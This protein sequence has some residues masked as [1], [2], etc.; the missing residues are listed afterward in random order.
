MSI[1]QIKADVALIVFLF[2]FLVSVCGTEFGIA[3]TSAIVE[4]ASK[5]SYLDKIEGKFRK[6]YFPPPDLGYC[7]ATVSFKLARDGKISDIQLIH[8][9]KDLK[10]PNLD[11]LA[12]RAVVAGVKNLEPLLQV[13]KEINCP[14]TIIMIIDGRMRGPMQ[15]SATFSSEDVSNGKLKMGHHKTHSRT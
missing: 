2:V 8:R 3:Q 7:I 11:D 4:K 6:V 5:Q 10:H 15:I 13:P 14:V 1:K 12:D 9:T